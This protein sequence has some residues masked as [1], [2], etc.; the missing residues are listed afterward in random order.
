M[1]FFL[2]FQECC[3]DRELTN[4]RTTRR[5]D[6]ASCSWKS[7]ERGRFT[8]DNGKFE[9]VTVQIVSYLNGCHVN[10]A[11]RE[12]QGSSFSCG[13]N[14]NQ[15]LTRSL[16]LRWVFR[17]NGLRRSGLRVKRSRC[18]FDACVSGSFIIYEE[19]ANLFWEFR[20]FSFLSRNWVRGKFRA[21]L[22]FIKLFFLRR[23]WRYVCCLF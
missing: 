19:A 22:H 20:C 16:M 1:C 17:L 23:Q 6:H 18:F 7:E 13:V 2:L 21:F 3:N 11:L 15:D 8:K 9:Q 4:K 12:H 14:P 10:M 5:E